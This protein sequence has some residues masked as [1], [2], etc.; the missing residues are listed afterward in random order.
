MKKEWWKKRKALKIFNLLILRAFWMVG[1]NRFERVATFLT[2]WKYNIKIYEILSTERLP[3]GGQPSIK[4]NFR[5]ISILQK[6]V[7][8]R[9]DSTRYKSCTKANQR[10]Y[11]CLSLDLP[12]VPS[13]NSWRI[14]QSSRPVVPSNYNGRESPLFQTALL[15]SSFRMTSALSFAAESIFSV[16]ALSDYLLRHVQAVMRQHGTAEA[17]FLYLAVK[18]YGSEGR[19]GHL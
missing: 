17:V 11:N 2:C 1:A 6:A 13:R 12:V 14:I 4:S 15:P 8:A 19:L 16:W 3:N 7:R 5:K 18:K 9:A 10:F